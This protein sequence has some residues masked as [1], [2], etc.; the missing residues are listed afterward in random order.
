MWHYKPNNILP[1]CTTITKSAKL[2]PQ[3]TAAIAQMAEK[4]IADATSGLQA[5]L[6]TTDENWNTVVRARDN[7]ITAFAV[8]R[9]ILGIVKETAVAKD[10]REE[11]SKKYLELEQFYNAN[12]RYNKALYEKFTHVS[13]K[14]S[15]YKDSAE[16]SYYVQETLEDFAHLGLSAPADKF[17]EIQKI[18]ERIQVKSTAFDNAISADTTKLSFHREDLQGVPADVVSS[19]KADPSDA[20]KVLVGLDYPTYFAVMRACEVAATRARLARAFENR[21]SPQNIATLREMLIERQTFAAALNF[22]N[23]A[24][25]DLYRNMVRTPATVSSFLAKAIEPLQKKWRAELDILKE[26][27]PES[28]KLTDD[29]RLRQSDLM[30]TMH[31]YK[32]KHLAVDENKI[33]EY[34]PVKHTIPMIFEVLGEFLNVTFLQADIAVPFWADDVFAMTMV[35]NDTDT[36]LGHIIFD[37]YPREGKYGHACCGSMVPSIQTERGPSPALAIVLANFPRDTKDSPGLLMHSDVETLFHEIGHAVHAIYGRCEMA[38]LAAYNV[39][40][41]FVEVPSQVI[42]EWAWDKDVLRRIS[43]HYEARDPLPDALIDAKLKA[44]YFFAGYAN[45]RQIL[46]GMYSLGVHSDAVGA[47]TDLDAKMTAL[48]RDLFPEI[49]PVPESHFACSFGHLSGYAAAYYSYHYSKAFAVDVLSHIKANGGVFNAA[50]G[51]KYKEV[52]LGRGGSVAPTTIMR[53]FLGREPSLDAYWK[54]IGIE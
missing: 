20:A 29:G 54:H 44:R 37:L 10:A 22:Q 5:I 25:W 33:R 39:K 52:I 35:D 31:Q 27:L 42:E 4:A 47:Q 24:E 21:A 45:L 48:W 3:T 13:E 34:F 12:F 49:E 1:D 36:H 41:D 23:Y 17:S 8:T 46:L 32:A 43:Q 19:L 7:T 38:T 2:F 28:V 40:M 53:E 6:G 51:R 11:A 15:E 9:D 26:A 50:I 18:N 14:T 16:R 30:F